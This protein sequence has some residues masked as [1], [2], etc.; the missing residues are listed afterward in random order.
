MRIIRYLPGKV[1]RERSGRA[2]PDGGDTERDEDIF[3][4]RMAA[5]LDCREEIRYGLL[6]V[7]IESEDCVA[8][9]SEAIDRCEVRKNP[10]RTEEFDLLFSESGYVH[11]MLANE[12][13]HATLELGRT[14]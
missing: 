14:R 13:L 3:E 11:S 1:L 9:I 8:M 12:D 10:E 5:C 4:F 7:S 6:A 2:T